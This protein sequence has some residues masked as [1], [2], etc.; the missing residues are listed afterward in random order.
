L[1]GDDLSGFPRR[2]APGQWR[3]GHPT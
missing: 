1:L 2:S 3:P